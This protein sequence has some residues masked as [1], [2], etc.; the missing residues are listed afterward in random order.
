MENFVQVSSYDRDSFFWNIYW[1]EKWYENG[2]ANHLDCVKPYHFDR[3]QFTYNL[4]RCLGWMEDY[5]AYA[6]KQ[7]EKYAKIQGGYND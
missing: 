2:I 1:E 5:R 7:D 4:I 6:K 3:L